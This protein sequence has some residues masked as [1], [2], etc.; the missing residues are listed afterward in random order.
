M[1]S[2]NCDSFG[3]RFTCRLR[4]NRRKR[5]NE[6][7]TSPYPIVGIIAMAIHCDI[8]GH[9][10]VREIVES[11][12]RMFP[13][14]KKD[15]ASSVQQGI[16]R[17]NCFYKVQSQ[18]DYHIYWGLDKTKITHDAF[19]LRRSVLLRKGAWAK[20]L[21]EHLKTM[22]IVVPVLNL[23]QKSFA[24]SNMLAVCSEDISNRRTTDDSAVFKQQT[25][26][27]TRV[28]TPPI[29]VL[30]SSNNASDNFQPPSVTKRQQMTNE[31]R[32]F[33]DVFSLPDKDV[34]ASSQ[35]VVKCD[36]THPSLRAMCE[37]KQLITVSP[38]SSF[39]HNLPSPSNNATLPERTLSPVIK[40]ETMSPG[41]QS[42]EMTS[43]CFQ[44]VPSSNNSSAC[45]S[46][47]YPPINSFL[48]RE[49]TYET[50]QSSV[51]ISHSGQRTT[52]DCVL[53]EEDTFD[54]IFSD[55]FLARESIVD[56]NSDDPPSAC[57]YQVRLRNSV[58]AYIASRSSVITYSRIITSDFM[59]EIYPEN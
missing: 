25:N 30:S 32:E 52:N 54:S 34:L 29:D 41:R 8:R 15:W 4:G 42:P 31:K 9:L 3:T 59:E 26:T 16:R 37:Q 5:I 22:S 17:H 56:R 12:G 27:R 6:I 21:F 50:A 1:A 47:E 18:S 38:S 2:N 58:K 44:F 13:G 28:T 10:T 20:N 45:E 35:L 7:S 55:C 39:E 24:G 48:K 51:A 53:N 11:V 33:T 14:T 57:P 36:S 49:D 46:E 19:R 23:D 40:Q 43:P